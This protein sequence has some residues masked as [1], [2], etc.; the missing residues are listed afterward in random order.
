AATYSLR[1]DAINSFLES[2]GTAPLRQSVKL[3]QLILRPQLTI[4]NLATNLPELAEFINNETEIERR[5]EIIEATEIKIKYQGYIDRER[6]IA[7]KLHRLEGVRLNG[8]IDYST[9]SSLSTEARQKLSKIQPETIA[10]ASRIP[11]ISPADINILL[12]LLG[13]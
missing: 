11:G 12:L 5:E 4:A 8:K 13:R 3:D 9:V 10:Q 7:D 2:A 1:P 6:T